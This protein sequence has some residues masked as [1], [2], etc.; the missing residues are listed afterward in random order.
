M[1]YLHVI[2]PR[3]KGAEEIR[4]DPPAI[5]AE[6]LRASFDGTIIV[7]G[8]FTRET[9]EHILELGHADLV[10]FVRHFIS[11][12]DLVRRFQL[13]APLAPYDRARF[14]GEGARCHIDY[15]FCTEK[16]TA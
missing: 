11:N 16:A 14:Y 12:P 3:I 6:R 15:P 2:E 10:A 9:A 7:A 8:G 13:G 1:G 5:S 4:E